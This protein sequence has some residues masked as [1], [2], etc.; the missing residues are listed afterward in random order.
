MSCKTTSVHGNCCLLGFS[1]K[2]LSLFDYSHSVAVVRHDGTVFYIPIDIDIRAHCALDLRFVGIRQRWLQGAS[3][4]Q[5][6]CEHELMFGD[7]KVKYCHVL[8]IPMFCNVL[9]NVCTVISTLIFTLQYNFLFS[10]LVNKMFC[11]VFFICL[12]Q[13]IKAVTCISNTEYPYL[14]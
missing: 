13:R 3:N 11:G 2:G 14:P 9:K 5:L 4:L 12:G 1:D 10:V 7:Q 8:V 6:V